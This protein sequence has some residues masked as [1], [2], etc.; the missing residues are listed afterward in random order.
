VQV[1]TKIGDR[2]PGIVQGEME[3][4]QVL[5]QDTMLSDFYTRTL[6]IQSYL[7]EVTVMA[8]HVSHRYPHVNVLEIGMI[9][10]P[11]RLLTL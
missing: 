4:N 1:M 5:G 10:Y 8:R 3:L 2:I 9:F 7:E 11:R 6:G